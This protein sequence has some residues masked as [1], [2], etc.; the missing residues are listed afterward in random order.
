MEVEIGGIEVIDARD[1]SDRR[2]S[3][4]RIEVIDARCLADMVDILQR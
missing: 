3:G 1:L 2:T 4:H